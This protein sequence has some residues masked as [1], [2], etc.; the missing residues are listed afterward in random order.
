MNDIAP[1]PRTLLVAEDQPADVML[2]RRAFAKSQARMTLRFVADGQEAIDYL[3]GEHEYADRELN[4]LP[5][6]ML[7][8]INM[9]R[10]DG[11]EV[12]VWL[13]HQPRLRRLPV[14]I[15]SSCALAN[16]V[17]RAYDLGVN[18]FLVKPQEPDGISDLI[19]R[20]EEFWLQLNQGPDWLVE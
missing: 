6:L 16:E 7:L 17:N 5:D 4:P 19:R 2:L 14:S 9:P 13:R 8:D 18:C 20:L 10:L 15:F 11:F 12:L 3:S 1:T